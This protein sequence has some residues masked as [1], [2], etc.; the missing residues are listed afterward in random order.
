MDMDT[1]KGITVYVA[2]SGGVDSSVA[3]GLIK[4]AGY[5]TIGVTMN[6]NI[7]RNDCKASCCGIDGIADAMGAAD[8]LGIK[9]QVLNCAQDINEFIIDNFTNEYLN[10]R[11]PNPCVR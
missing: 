5:N 2:M 7:I 9:H 3:A 6:F 1:N 4:E 10:G 11:T 8:I